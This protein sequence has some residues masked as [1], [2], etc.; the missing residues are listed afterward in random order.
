LQIWSSY[1]FFGA[2]NLLSNFDMVKLLVRLFIFISIIFAEL[3]RHL[4]F[5]GSV[6]QQ[7]IG[8]T[9]FLTFAPLRKSA[10]EDLGLT[11]AT[12]P[13]GQEKFLL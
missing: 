12:D 5:R 4:E 7:K 1:V 11:S 9:A 2:I 8:T 13:P 6:S 3:V 10:D